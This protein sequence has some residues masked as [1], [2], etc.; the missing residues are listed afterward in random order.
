MWSARWFPDLNSGQGY[1]FLSFYAPLI[2]W[3][4]GAFHAAGAGVALALKLTTTLGVLLAAFGMDRLVR[5]HTQAR[6]AGFAAA[7]LFIYAPYFVRDIFIRGDLAESFAMSLLP[8]SVGAMLR[9]QRRAGA[10]DIAIAAF[11][12]AAPILAHNILGLFNGILLALTAAVAFATSGV[13]PRRVTLRAVCTAGIGALLLSAFFWMPALLEKKF[14]QIDV[15]T[16][17]HYEVAKH[18]VGLGQLLGRG[19]FPGEQDQGL[20]MSFELGWVGIAGVLAALVF[21]RSLWKSHR[22]L[23]ILGMLL[24]LVGTARAMK[25]SAPVYET[26]A[27][28]RYVQFPWR[29]LSIAALGAAIL[30]GLAF[31]QL[32]SRV[33]SRVQAVAA[34][35]TALAAILFVWPVL[36]PR[37]NFALPSW[38]LDPAQYRTKRETTTV[39]EYLPIWALGQE[40]PKGFENGVKIEGGGRIV[41]AERRAGRLDAIL[42]LTAPSDILFQDLYFPGWSG[43]SNG[44]EIKLF[45]DETSGHIAAQLSEGRQ[46]VELRLQRTPLRNATLLVSAAAALLFLANIVVRRENSSVPA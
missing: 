30:G 8:W 27:I 14:V 41:S 3:I 15:M 31:E 38:A 32:L 1:P 9:L 20:P 13:Q 10:R 46:E 18:F 24:F 21:A 26:F 4:A 43:R 23:F 2:F 7:A 28:L 42:E 11:A 40:A 25:V 34:V 12:G 36:G 44:N 33:S 37:P 6:G 16:S 17:G 22:A 35:L 45:P 19:E 39:G 29:F 5:E